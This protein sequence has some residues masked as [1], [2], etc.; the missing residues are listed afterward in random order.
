[1]L[2]SGVLVNV[3]DLV[4]NDIDIH[5]IAHALACTNRFGGHARVPLSVAQ[6]S[7]DV[8]RICG[9]LQGLL[10]DASEAYLGDIPQPLKHSPTFEDY[11]RREEWL[12]KMIYA[13]YGCSVTD[14]PAVKEA[15]ALILRWEAWQLFD[16]PFWCERPDM[17]PEI[18][19]AWEPWPWHRAEQEFLKRFEELTA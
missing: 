6:H 7:V 1:M 2:Y 15:D 14:T 12:Q 16:N 5:D 11:R 9:S 10:H 13:K 17:I 3:L 18:G 19:P 4:P 8:S